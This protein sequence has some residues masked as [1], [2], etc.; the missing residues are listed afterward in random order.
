MERERG[1]YTLIHGEREK[2]THPYCAKYGGGAHHCEENT[3]NPL[4]N[5]CKHTV[6]ISKRLPPTETRRN[7]TQ[8]APWAKLLLKGKLCLVDDTLNYD[9]YTPWWSYQVKQLVS[10][11]PH[12]FIRS[13]VVFQSADTASFGPVLKKFLTGLRRY[14]PLP[15]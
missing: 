7:W 2:G 12:A 15:V 3:G 14:R 10:R 13:L 1:K 8:S 11:Q 9:W 4:L 6:V 5:R